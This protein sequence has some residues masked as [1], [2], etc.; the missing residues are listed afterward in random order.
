VLRSSLG[1]V[2]DP[3][4]LD[5]GV[6]PRARLRIEVPADWFVEGADL[7]VTAP[8]RLSCARCDGG[9]CDACGRSGVLRAP[10]DAGA[11]VVHASVPRG[12]GGSSAIVLRIPCPFGPASGIEQLLLEVRA[13]TGASP[14]VARHA[15]QSVAVAGGGH[16]AWPVLVAVA[17]A[18][19]FA[20]FGR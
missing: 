1:R 14:G 13:S 6:G 7:A 12:S 3:A 17:A 9:G 2:L 18:I 5:A 19:L 15:P 20:I 16:V 4:A 10:A 8:V 11:R